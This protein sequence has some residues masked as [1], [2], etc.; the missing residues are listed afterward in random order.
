[1]TP[2]ITPTELWRLARPGSVPLSAWEPGIVGDVTKTGS[3]SGSMVASGYPLDTIAAV[4]VRC[5]VGGEPGGLAR[6]KVSLDGGVTY[7][8]PLL[9]VPADD[10]QALPLLCA[11]EVALTF[12]AGAAPSFAV[13]DVF[14]FATTAS[15]E[16]LA[17]IEAV[18]SDC[19]TYLRDVF[20]LPLTRW[21][22]SIKRNVARRVR[23]ALLTQR[24]LS[25][26]EGYQ[27]DDAQAV[28]WWESVARG[29]LRPDVDEGPG[30]ARTFPQVVKARRPYASDWRL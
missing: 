11:G 8:G 13:G 17:T 9:A 28:K 2:Y 5:F 19:D 21:D 4:R 26:A 24:G 30:G 6:V 22:A 18:G 20:A 23:Y 14:S 1:M 27:K 25:E 3:G 7:P 16:I 29:D 10:G 15:P 12:T